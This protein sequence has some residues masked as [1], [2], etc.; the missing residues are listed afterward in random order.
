MTKKLVKLKNWKD[1]KCKVNTYIWAEWTPTEGRPASI[2]ELLI[3]KLNHEI[4][5]TGMKEDDYLLGFLEVE[6]QAVNS[7]V[8]VLYIL[9]ARFMKYI[10]SIRTKELWLGQRLSMSQDAFITSQTWQI[11]KLQSEV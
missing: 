5:Q 2:I 1:T 6:L 11:P 9:S 10:F 4:H 8:A 7:Q 3:A